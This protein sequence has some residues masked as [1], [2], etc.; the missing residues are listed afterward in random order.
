MAMGGLVGSLMGAFGGRAIGGMLGGST[1]RMVG[2]LAGSVLGGR[3]MRGMGKGGAAAGGI[4]SM[5][6]G[7]FGGDDKEKEEAVA[8]IS[9]DDAKILI[10]AMCNA[11]KSDGHV[12]ED[13]V[14]NILGRVDDASEEEKDFLKAELESP[15]ELETFVRSVPAGMENEVYTVSLLAIDVD[16]AAEAD[17]LDKLAAGLGISRDVRDKIHEALSV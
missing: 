8:N 12:D 4:G 7:L 5:L 1:G 10:R 2:S 3:G 16:T 14:Q 15:I 17:Y 13:E 6:G 9:D 11:A